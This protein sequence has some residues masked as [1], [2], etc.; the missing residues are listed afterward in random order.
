MHEGGD[1]SPLLLLHGV[2]GTWRAWLP[3]LP[4]LE[5]LHHVIAPTLSGHDGALPLPPGAAPSIAAI[6]DALE[7][8]LDRRGIDRLHVV[9]NSLG[10]WLAL[11][12]A[13][14]GRA[15]SVVAFSPAGAWSSEVRMTALIAS[16]R[17]SF[18]LGGRLAPRADAIARSPRWRRMLLGSQVE[19]P[20]RLE[21]AEI[22]EEL[23]SITRSPIVRP[24]IRVLR[25]HP[26]LPLPAD[27]DRPV[28][29]VWPDR[30]RVIP[31]EHYGRPMMAR[32]PGAELVRMSGVGHVP[33]TDDPVG[34]TVTI[35]EVTRPLEH[36]VDERRG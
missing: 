18:L 35:L 19:Y 4:G 9:G 10:G 15:R 6:A 12:L 7:A 34:V 13:R 23:R 29:I 33:M 21:P 22:A 25:R 20:D 2:G 5:R 24:L 31:F 36:A 11:E 1:G 17:A 27:T 3:I 28:R 8:D 16:M 32:L 14:R 30:D 26:L